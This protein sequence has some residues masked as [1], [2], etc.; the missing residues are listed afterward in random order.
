MIESPQTATPVE[1][2]TELYRLYVEAF[3]IRED[4]SRVL[5]TLRRIAGDE[6][7]HYRKTWKFTRD[8]V[9]R[10]AE[11]KA[12]HDR[13]YVGSNARTYLDKYSA[14]GA[15]KDRNAAEQAPLH[16]EYKRRPWTRAFLVTDGHVHSSTE[17]STCF[18][19]TRF[20]WLVDLA[21]KDEAEIVELAGE[22]AC[23]VCYPTAPTLRSFEKASPLFTEEEAARKAARDQ[24]D[25]ERADRLAKKIEKGLTVDGSEFVVVIE[26]GVRPDTYFHEPSRGKAYQRKEHFKT[27][28]AAV[29]WVVQQ[30]AWGHDTNRTAD[31]RTEQ[32]I[33][34]VIQAVATKHSKTTDEVRAEIRDKVEAK[35]KRDSRGY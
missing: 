12:D 2:D 25:K 14:L 32:A 30:I 35:R 1:I 23:T 24:R 19:T 16:A 31:D 28:K 20:T 18:E 15:E 21:A 8:E 5:D 4:R 34:A 13:T 27:E 9:L 11:D 17:C 10:L 7:D 22:R 3:S 29:Q 6:Y 26:E 33:E